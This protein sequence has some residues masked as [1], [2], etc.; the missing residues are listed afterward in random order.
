MGNPFRQA[1]SGPQGQGGQ[2]NLAPALLQHI[3]SFQGDPM[4]QLQEKINSSGVNQ[5]QVN[6]L[7]S[8]AEKIAQRM[9]GGP[10]DKNRPG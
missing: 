3:Q 5:E 10:A 6:Q 1:M 2:R 9:M 4:Q 7:Y 8:A